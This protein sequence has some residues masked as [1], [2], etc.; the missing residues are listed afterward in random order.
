MDYKDIFI[1]AII[2]IVFLLIIETGSSFILSRHSQ[3]ETPVIKSSIYKETD[4]VQQLSDEQM[5]SYS[6]LYESFVGYKPKP[7]SGTY[8]NIDNNSLRQTKNYNS[9]PDP[10][11]I[12]CYGGSTMWGTDS[13]D[14]YTIPS[15]L[16]KILYKNGYN[17]I[18]HNYGMSGYDSNTELI[19]FQME[20]KKGNIPDIAIFYDG[21]NDPCNAY[22]NK[23][24]GAIPNFFTREYQYN[25]FQDQNKRSIYHDAFHIIT[26]Q[27]DAIKLTKILLNKFVRTQ[28]QPT[29]ESDL[30][31]IGY[32]S[33]DYYSKNIQIIEDIGNIYN[34]KTIFFI[35][36]YMVTRTNPTDEEINIF[37]NIKKSFPGM[38]IT[39]NAFYESIKSS[40]N[41]KIIYIGSAFNSYNNSIYID[42]CH[43]S[44]K[45]NEIVTKNIFNYLQFFI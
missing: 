16:S 42:D 23:K 41:P 19:Q 2:T 4:W 9:A 33:F 36:P 32:D 34:V 28:Y 40:N 17:V 10:I 37:N 39:C 26:T 25:Y 45:G 29:N 12:H 11:I 20:L 27:S 1:V 5:E 18:V 31:I 3:F 43:I 35:Q 14:E 24:A 6:F 13:R 8:V 38:E 22:L 44:E 7:Y 21:V 30:Q 15:Q